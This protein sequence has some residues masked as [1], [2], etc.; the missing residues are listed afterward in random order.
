LEYVE[1]GIRLHAERTRRCAHQL[2][3][4][5]SDSTTSSSSSSTIWSGS[6]EGLSELVT[7][8]CR[9]LLV[10]VK[11]LRKLFK[12]FRSI[13]HSFK[14][15]GKSR[16][17]YSNEQKQCLKKFASVIEG[18]CKTVCAVCD[19]FT[20][21]VLRSSPTEYNKNRNKNE[22]KNGK[23]TKNIKS[24]SKNSNKNDKI[25]GIP[26]DSMLCKELLLLVGKSAAR[27]LSVCCRPLPFPREKTLTDTGFHRVGCAVVTSS[28][29]IERLVHAY[30]SVA[31]VKMSKNSLMECSH[32]CVS[33]FLCPSKSSDHP[34]ATL[35]MQLSGHLTTDF[36]CAAA[37]SW[38]TQKRPPLSTYFF[39][40]LTANFVE[41]AQFVPF[42]VVALLAD[43]S[44]VRRECLSMNADLTNNIVKILVNDENPKNVAIG[45]PPSLL[46]GVL[47]WFCKISA[48]LPDVVARDLAGTFQEGRQ[49]LLEDSKT[50]NP[51]L[52]TILWLQTKQWTAVATSAL[53]ASMRRPSSAEDEEIQKVEKGIS[54]LKETFSSAKQQQVYQGSLVTCLRCAKRSMQLLSEKFGIPS[55]DELV[56]FLAAERLS[57]GSLRP[58]HEKSRGKY[59]AYVAELEVFLGLK[60][61]KKNKL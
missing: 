8:E 20:A 7:D 19:E 2:N 43:H 16:Q 32:Q 30:V 54:Q 11:V 4:S 38:A 31:E 35:P 45:V 40:A 26:D 21:S 48:S 41:F 3:T 52:A 34:C 1:I 25:D 60:S 49:Q 51:H 24:G 13:I 33:T 15:S 46:N 59:N 61:D 18:C 22:N 5:H 50:S 44:F 56:D 39:R 42:D 17:R 23:N 55:K 53:V 10:C 36:M 29:S 28:L 37:Y 47:K 6:S 9:S 12:C 27:S 57:L 58:R 14:K